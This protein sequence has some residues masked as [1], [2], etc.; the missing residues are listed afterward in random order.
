M[1]MAPRL[2]MSSMKISSKIPILP[3]WTLVD[4]IPAKLPEHFILRLPNYVLRVFPL[5]VGYPSFIWG[6]DSWT[7][8]KPIFTV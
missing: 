4:L 5:R 3:Q 7:V 6:D 8:E 1:L 2:Q